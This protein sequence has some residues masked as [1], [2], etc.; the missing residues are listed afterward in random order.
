MTPG[1]ACLIVVALHLT[2]HTSHL[3]A[4]SPQVRKLRA[5]QKAVA[6]FDRI[7]TLPRQVRHPATCKR[8]APCTPM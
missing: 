5:L 1:T 8:Q 2:P 4:P 7:S 6:L 3:H